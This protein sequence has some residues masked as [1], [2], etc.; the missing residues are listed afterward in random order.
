MGIIDVNVKDALS[1]IGDLAKDVRTAITGKDPALDAKLAE[2]TNQVNLAQLK[3][4]ETEAA[5]ASIWVSGWRPFVGWI[6]GTA[7]AVQYLVFPVAAIFMP[8]PA[9]DFS[10]LINLLLALLGIATLRTI[11]KSKG[12]AS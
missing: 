6:C 3:V 1:G 11:E 5:S 4:N 9:Y 10:E 8:V 12:V 2:L 7:L